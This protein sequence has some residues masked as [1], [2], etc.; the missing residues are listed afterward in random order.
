MNGPSQFA[1]PIGI[2]RQ[3]EISRPRHYSVLVNVSARKRH[4]IPKGRENSSIGAEDQPRGVDDSLR[5]IDEADLESVGRQN[6]YGHNDPGDV[7]P[8][9][10]GGI[11]F[12]VCRFAHRSQFSRS[13]T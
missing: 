12:G 3:V 2:R 1:M 4:G 13:A 6:I 5:P 10:S 9:S 8:Y 7:S 11:F